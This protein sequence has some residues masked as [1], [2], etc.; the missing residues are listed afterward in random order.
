MIY[1]IVSIYVTTFDDYE[2]YDISFSENGKLN[3]IERLKKLNQ[4][5]A[6]AK[7][8]LSTMDNYLTLSTCYGGAGTEKRLVVHARLVVVQ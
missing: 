4:V 5:E 6:F 1:E 3:F 7:D 2:Y 8:N